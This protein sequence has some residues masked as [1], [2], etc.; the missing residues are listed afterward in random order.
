MVSLKRLLAL[1]EVVDRVE[2]VVANKFVNSAMNMI[3]ARLQHHV[4]SGAAAPKL[5]AH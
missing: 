5:R 3:A 1:V 2:F 4:H